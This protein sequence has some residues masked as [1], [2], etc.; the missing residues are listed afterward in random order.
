M[1]AERHDRYSQA[2]TQ[3]WSGTFR[4]AAGFAVA[5]RGHLGIE[6]LWV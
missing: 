6:I 1:G 5:D 4:V 3:L 2:F